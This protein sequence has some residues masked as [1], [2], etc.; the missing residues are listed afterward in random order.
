M[1]QRFIACVFLFVFL[2]FGDK[3]VF[4]YVWGWLMRGD[5]L[6]WQ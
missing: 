4:N 1:Q 5:F 3:T 2:D 6:V